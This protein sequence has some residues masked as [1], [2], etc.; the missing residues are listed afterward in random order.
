[1][2]DICRF[3]FSKGIGSELIESQIILAI[4][5]AEY[6]F[7]QAKVRSTAGYLV[8]KNKAVIDVSNDVGEYIVQIFTWLMIK[9]PGENKFTVERVKI[10]NN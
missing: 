3:K 5:T 9:Q 8:S 6:A 10:K 1:M 7:D 4:A 2:M